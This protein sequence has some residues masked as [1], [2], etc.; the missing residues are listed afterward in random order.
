[1]FR[2]LFQTI[3]RK[4]SAVGMFS[5]LLSSL[6]YAQPALAGRF[7]SAEIPGVT[8]GIAKCVTTAAAQAS[9]TKVNVGSSNFA[10]YLSQHADYVCASNFVCLADQGDNLCASVAKLAGESTH[11]ACAEQLLDCKKAPMLST[12]GLGSVGPCPVARPHCC[13]QVSPAVSGSD[14]VSS[15]SLGSGSSAP[16]GGGSVQV[17]DPLNGADIPSLIG[18][19]VRTFA[20]IAGSIALAIFVWGGFSYILSG[21]ESSKVKASTE[22]LRNA[23]IGIVLIFGAYMLTATI[24]NAI[25]IQNT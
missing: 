8:D 4:A 11:Y 24:I 15:G 6:L 1:M 16:S 25:L 12:T 21:G 18:N 17:P 14:T 3:L 10:S 19:I 7:C 23:S 20:G 22:M 2:K 13:E 5:V 9:E